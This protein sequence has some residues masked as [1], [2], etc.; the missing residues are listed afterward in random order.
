MRTFL[1]TLLF[2]H[3]LMA[4]HA[5]QPVPLQDSAEDLRSA[6]VLFSI[7]D[8]KEKRHYWLERSPALDH[9]LRLKKGSEEVLKKADSRD[10]K[11][12]DM[13]FAAGFLRCQ[14]QLPT[15]PG[16]CRV[17]Y[18]LNMKGEEQEICAKDDKK[19]QEIQVFLKELSKR[20]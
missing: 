9:F 19:S 11:K 18:K 16:D 17:I 6:T 3:Q 4:Q 1:I 5:E 13:S 12:L 7:E 15:A 8:V 14:Y 20:F 10:A 2:S